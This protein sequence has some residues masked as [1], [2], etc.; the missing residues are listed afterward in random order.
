MVQLCTGYHLFGGPCFADLEHHY[1][2][3]VLGL[4]MRLIALLALAAVNFS[5]TSWPKI[6]LLQSS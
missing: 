1:R 5:E 2:R 3:G 6:R 4:L